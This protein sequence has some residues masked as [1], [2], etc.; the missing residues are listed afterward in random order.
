MVQS[1]SWNKRQIPKTQKDKRLIRWYCLAHWKRKQ[2]I[3]HLLMKALSRANLNQMS[4]RKR[5]RDLG[6]PL[7][8]AENFSQTVLTNKLSHPSRQVLRIKLRKEHLKVT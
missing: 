4:N 6:H 1:E 2:H 3:K 5:T 8:W 7:N